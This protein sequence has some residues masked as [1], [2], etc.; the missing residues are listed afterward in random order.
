M[1]AHAIIAHTEHSQL[2]AASGRQTTELIR[3]FR[4]LWIEKWWNSRL[5]SISFSARHD[6]F[7]SEVLNDES[8]RD[9]I[10]TEQSNEANGKSCV[11]YYGLIRRSTIKHLHRMKNRPKIVGASMTYRQKENTNKLWI[12]CDDLVLALFIF[13]PM[14]HIICSE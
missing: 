14:T 4:K 5:D 2:M 9:G 8:I 11:I 10:L 3:N 7:F 6:I 13:R 1:W 12:I